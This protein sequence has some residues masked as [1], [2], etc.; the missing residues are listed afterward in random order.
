MGQDGMNSFNL[1]TDA[2][3]T[4]NEELGMPVDKAYGLHRIV[5]AGYEVENV[6]PKLQKGGS[7]VVANTPSIVEPR[8]YHEIGDI[9]GGAPFPIAMTY[10]NS[11]PSWHN[12][13]SNQIQERQKLG[14]S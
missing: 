2:E 11:I 8:T 1:G 5:A 6:T 4:L 9:D 13:G 14:C 10:L 3:T 7:V 12:K